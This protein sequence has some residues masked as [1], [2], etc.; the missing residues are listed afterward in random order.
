ME[1]I[2]GTGLEFRA[3]VPG[4]KK[5]KIERVFCRMHNGNQ[6]LG[7]L[8]PG[9]QVFPGG[10]TTTVKG[11][12]IVFGVTVTVHVLPTCRVRHAGA[13]LQTNRFI[14]VLT[15][16]QGCVEM[17]GKRKLRAH[18]NQHQHRC[19]DDFQEFKPPICADGVHV[20]Y[21]SLFIPS[22]IWSGFE[23]LPLYSSRT[24]PCLSSNEMRLV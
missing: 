12:V 13:I 9:D 16:K 14:G 1:D 4:R 5:R 8:D 7:Q 11:T 24:R 18:K 22:I 17:G 10:I 2:F 21:L 19:D 23:K 20:G 6:N 3:V 15:G